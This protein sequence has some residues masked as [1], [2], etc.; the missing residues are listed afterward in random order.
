MPPRI[1]QEDPFADQL[2]EEWR[3]VVG[4]E[5]Y[6]EVSSVGRIKRLSRIVSCNDGR[7]YRIPEKLMSP[8]KEKR[9]GHLFID[10]HV[11]GNDRK[12]QVHTLVLETFVGPKPN[13]TECRHLNGVPDDNRVENI[14]WGT[15]QENADDRERHGVN[16]G[17]R[18]NV[19]G[20]VNGSAKLVTDRVLKMRALHAT[21]K[22]TL[23]SLG[24]IFGVSSVMVRFIV[25]RE[26]WT[27]IP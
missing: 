22:F 2:I 6:Y 26:A 1:L 12:T 24:R 3:P 19:K 23:A 9:G 5:R 10:L 4:W 13:G 18:G 21:G 25:K 16:V 7:T 20:E 8:Y 11:D 15:R 17:C 14:C 27:H